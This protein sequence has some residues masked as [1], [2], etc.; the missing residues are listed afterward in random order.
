MHVLHALP[1]KMPYRSDPCKKAGKN[2]G[3]RP[4]ALH[5]LR[6]LRGRMPEKMPEYAH[7]VFAF[8]YLKNR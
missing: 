2:M 4:P 6:R 1:E 5:L 3:N 8:R 7:L